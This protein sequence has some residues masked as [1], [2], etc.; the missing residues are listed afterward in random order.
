MSETIQT[1][2]AL[3]RRTE[4]AKAE[5]CQLISIGLLKLMLS[6]RDEMSSWCIG[7]AK[8]VRQNGRNL[9]MTT[10]FIIMITFLAQLVEL[11]I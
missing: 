2:W 9:Q 10:I 4:T 8:S 7:L 3:Y 6:V 11:F 5:T 1:Q